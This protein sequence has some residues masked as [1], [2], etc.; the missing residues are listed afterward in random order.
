MAK[1]AKQEQEKTFISYNA[2]QAIAGM[3]RGFKTGTYADYERI[4]S[5]IEVCKKVTDSFQ[6]RVQAKLQELGVEELTPEHPEFK[7]VNTELSHE[8]S[9]A[10]STEVKE[11]QVFTKEELHAS[12]EGINMSFDERD[13][14]EKALVKP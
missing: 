11:L 2:A 4:K 3:V 13:L 12:L 8:F 10:S 7:K 6:E 9:G 14:L 5:V 1:K